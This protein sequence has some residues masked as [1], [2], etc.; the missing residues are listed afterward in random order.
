MTP[1]TP[2]APATPAAC[3][4]Q[5]RVFK[6]LGHPTRL[7]I[8]LELGRGERCVRELQEFVGD[9]MS[10]VSRHLAALREA[11]LVRDERR[12]SQVFYTLAA[13]CVLGFM[14]CIEGLAGPV[15]VRIGEFQASTPE[16][17]A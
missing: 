17:P 10:T 12:G 7:F 5:A 14:S 2:N 4:R 6:A 8:V 13:P 15:A 3:R 9:D 11:G 16:E 1:A